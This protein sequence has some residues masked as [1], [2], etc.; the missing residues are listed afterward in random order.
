MYGQ[1]VESWL[2]RF[3]AQGRSLWFMVKWSNIVVLVPVP[4]KGILAYICYNLQLR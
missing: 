4:G 2:E 3:C 1:I